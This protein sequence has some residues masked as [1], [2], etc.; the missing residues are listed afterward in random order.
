[1]KVNLPD[2]LQRRVAGLR[3]ASAVQEPAERMQLAIELA[4][5]NVA[6]GT[7]G[8]FGALVCDGEGR[9][10]G[11]GVNLV[12]KQRCSLLHAEVVALLLAQERT[13]DYDLG[14]AVAAPVLTTSVD[15]C[16]MCFGALVWAR[17]RRLECGASTA[18]A[19]AIG[20][21]EGP[22]PRRW[23]AALE[24]RGIRVVRPLLRASAAAVLKAYAAGGG[25]R[26]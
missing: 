3:H 4:R 7:G 8:P 25:P 23:V 12:T 16:V 17:I 18:D 11:L 13:G 14:R 26:Y 15:P 9:L 19:E 20:F 1:M 6:R 10:L 5:E 2:W 21:D 24:Q 22:K